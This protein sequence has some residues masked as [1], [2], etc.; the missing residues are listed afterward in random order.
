MS[1]PGHNLSRLNAKKS[2]AVNPHIVVVDDDA[3]LRMLICDAIELAEEHRSDGR[4]P[5]I[6]ECSSGEDALTFLAGCDPLPSLIY[7]DVEMPGM[8][9]IEAVK[10]LKAD[11]RLR[12]VPVVILSGLQD[13]AQR[14][15]EAG[16][17][18]DAFQVKPSDAD[19][20]IETVLQSTDYWLHI[21][22]EETTSAVS[23]D[24]P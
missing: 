6:T 23:T 24:A 5:T 2:A 4:T 15:R 11:A 19:G 21:R 13:V 8:G 16:C 17:H 9:G 10:R 1:A 3:D 7:M 20:L 12:H 14:G 18:A 22:P